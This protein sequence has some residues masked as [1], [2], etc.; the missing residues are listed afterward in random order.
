MLVSF[1]KAFIVIVGFV[2]RVTC[3]LVSIGIAA[4]VT[5]E[6]TQSQSSS[7]KPDYLHD[8]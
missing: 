4:E 5:Q 3:D 1:V 8:K 2:V 6:N 7:A